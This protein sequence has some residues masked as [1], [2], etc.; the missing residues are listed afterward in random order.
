MKSTGMEREA[1][2]EMKYCPKCHRAMNIELEDFPRYVQYYCHGRDY[3][4]MNRRHGHE[5]G[6][7]VRI[8]VERWQNT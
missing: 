4:L 3:H 6:L 8:V 7:G 5:D 1:S 2:I